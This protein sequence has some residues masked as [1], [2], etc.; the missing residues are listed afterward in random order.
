VPRVVTFNLLHGISLADGL[1]SEANLTA[2]A[3]ATGAAILGLQE[4]DRGQPRSASADQTAVAAAALDAPHWRFA[5]ALHGT[6]GGSWVPA[7][8]GEDRPELPGYGVGLVSRYPVRRWLVW[9][10][11]GAP[12]SLPLLIPGGRG[13]IRVRDE[14]RIALAA[15]LDTPSGPLTAITAH[16]SFVP[17]WNAGQLR[18]LASWARGLPGPRL[19]LGDFNLPGPMP[20]LISGWRQLARL[21]TYPVTRPRVQFDHVLGDGVPADAVVRAEVLRLPISD[22]CALAVDLDL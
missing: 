7:R 20:R 21:A 22:H 18:S 12:V 1:I 13:L 19:L 17:G 16:L 15:I 6:P 3:A 14:P 4:V 10:F 2:S 11:P 8:A 5:A 9:R